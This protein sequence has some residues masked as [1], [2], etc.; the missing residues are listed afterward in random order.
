M[1]VVWLRLCGRWQWV[2]GHGVWVRVSTLHGAWLVSRWF[3]VGLKVL[4]VLVVEAAIPFHGATTSTC[5]S[6]ARRGMMTLA[7]GQRKA[8]RGRTLA[9]GRFWRKAARRWGRG[10]ALW[11]PRRCGH[12]LT[13]YRGVS[14]VGPRGCR[15]L[16]QL[17][18]TS[19]WRTGPRG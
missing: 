3:V 14:D 16:R 4:V 6:P 5:V 8:G 18:A 10:S 13:D 19:A 2:V 12:G 9:L 17:P 7:V 1:G 11:A 15:G